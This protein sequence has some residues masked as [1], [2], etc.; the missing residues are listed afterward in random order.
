MYV[1]VQQVEE[2]GLQRLATVKSLAALDEETV[3]VA[4]STLAVKAV[5][6]H[7]RGSKAFTK[8]MQSE[9]ADENVLFYL[10]RASRASNP[11]TL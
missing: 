6:A 1:Q 7:P 2:A 4:N 8:F 5:L 3:M 11:V 9:F 10:V